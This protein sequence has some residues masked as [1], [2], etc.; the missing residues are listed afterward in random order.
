MRNVFSGRNFLL[1]ASVVM[2]VEN[3][4][5]KKL[6]YELQSASAN[7]HFPF[8]HIESALIACIN[9]NLTFAI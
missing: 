4:K 3:R 1:V 2:E 9:F 7:E 8:S 6:N 5:K